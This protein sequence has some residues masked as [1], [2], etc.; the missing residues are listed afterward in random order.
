[1]HQVRSDLLAD[2]QAL[3]GDV[4]FIFGHTHQPFERIWD[5]SSLGAVKLYNT[6][7]WAVDPSPALQPHMGG[8]AVLLD[9]EL[10]ATSLRFFNQAE[11]PKHYRVSLRTADEH[12]NPLHDRLAPLIQP[13]KDPYASFSRAA[14]ASV[15]RRFAVVRQVEDGESSGADSDE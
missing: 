10:N 1:M 13:D 4:T 7:G 5:G 11:D 9:D 6:G 8:A 2:G 12:G 15:K 14:A 3:P